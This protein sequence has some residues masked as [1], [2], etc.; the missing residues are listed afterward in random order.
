[1]RQATVLIVDDQ[2][3]VRSLLARVARRL[4]CRVLDAGDFQGFAARLAEQ[5]DVVLLD[6]VMPGADGIEL[7]QHMIGA[8]Y[9]GEV[10]LMSG[11][12]DFLLQVAHNLANARGMRVRGTLK[13][14]IDLDELRG[15]L[16]QAIE[17]TAQDA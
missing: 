12:Q 17:A 16:R 3:E 9:G 5:P 15:L 6:L 7:M 8:G 10:I 2:E 11:Y 1:M 13:K 14:P 4:G